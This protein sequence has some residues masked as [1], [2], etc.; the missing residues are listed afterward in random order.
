MRSISVPWGTSSTSTRGDI[1]SVFGIEPDVAGDRLATG[2][3]DQLSDA[4]AGH[5]VS[6][7]I[8]VRPRLRWPLVRPSPARACPVH[9]AADHEHAPSGIMAMASAANGFHW[10]V[11]PPSI[12]SAM[13]RICAAASEHRKSAA[14]PICCA[15]GELKRRLLLTE[16]LLILAAS[17]ARFSRRAKIVDLLL[18][19]R[20]EGPSPDRSRCK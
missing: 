5:R 11:Q 18:H 9:E 1:S 3:G 13:P 15:R 17:A 16:Q 2:G 14:A 10:A 8:T 7:A 19:Q 20:R 4:D 12:G 6:F